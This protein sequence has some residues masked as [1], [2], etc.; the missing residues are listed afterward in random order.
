MNATDIAKWFMSKGIAK[1][2][3]IVLFS[4]SFGIFLTAISRI[5]DFAIDRYVFEEESDAFRLRSLVLSLVLSIGVGMYLGNLAWKSQD[6]QKE[7]NSQGFSTRG[8]VI[9]QYISY[10]T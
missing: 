10:E 8:I 2:W 4:L 3:F 9:K 7:K 1:K 6:G 5:G